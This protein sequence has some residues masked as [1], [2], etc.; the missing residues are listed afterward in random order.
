MMSST[1]S[2]DSNEFVLPPDS[3]GSSVSTRLQEEYDE[4]LRF[5]V[6]VPSFDPTCMP[7]S[8]QD[9]RGSF[10]ET[11][12]NQTQQTEDG[13][14]NIEDEYAER[15]EER[16]HLQ[17]RE[18]VSTSE[19][20]GNAGE[21]HQSS[22]QETQDY[23]EG[24]TS[25]DN[26]TISDK[27]ARTHQTVPKLATMPMG[28]PLKA[29]LFMR[30]DSPS[31]TFSGYSHRDSESGS[32]MGDEMGFTVS[33]DQDLTRMESRVWPVKNKADWL[34]KKN[35][36]RKKEKGTWL[37]SR[38][39]TQGMDGLRELL[40]TYE[41][42]IERK[43]QVIANLTHALQKQKEKFEMLR[44]FSEWKISLNDKKR[45]VL[46]S[47]LAERHYHR[48]LLQKSWDG[49]HSIVESKWRER[50]EKA[51]QS[52]AQEV[53]MA[54][55]ND[56]ETKIAS[57]NEGLESSRNEV[58]RLHAEREQ[59]EETMKKAFMRGVCALNMEAMAIFQDQEDKGSEKSDGAEVA[60]MP[61][62][63]QQPVVPVVSS[64]TEEYYSMTVPQ[65]PVYSSN[66]PGAPAPRVVTS[67]AA[68]RGVVVGNKIITSQAKSGGATKFTKAKT[69]TAKLT[70]NVNV[71]R[72]AMLGNPTLVP[73]MSS[74]VV[75]RHQPIVKQTVGQATASRYVKAS[76]GQGQVAK[77]PVQ[78]KIAGQHPQA[79][80]IVE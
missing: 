78:R 68:S 37:N 35:K 76:E 32:L 41:Q 18:P 30:P 26:S 66:P 64:Q 46:A 36:H 61:Q 7:K 23:Q 8:L 48:L 19:H 12:N 73:P 52:K 62:Q 34:T 16:P 51:C 72:G 10:P 15:E 56:Y 6:V 42:S 14:Y 2:E 29:K 25:N 40:H 13:D 59:Y 79:V 3:P 21:S 75:E 38:D 20:T 5:A 33:V 4:L 47:K 65:E 67:Q 70:G 9:I 74:V 49:W 17:I 50:V 71:P 22:R 57:L 45:E 24:F 27:N 31:S 80:K 44:T 77:G 39:Y 28:D 55:T 63:Q 43:D 53:C 54:L 58:I 69:I 60:Q 11:S 1:I